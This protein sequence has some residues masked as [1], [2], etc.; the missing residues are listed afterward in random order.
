MIKV[1]KVEK[2]PVILEREKTRI[3]LFL[4]KTFPGKWMAVIPH[5]RNSHAEVQMLLSLRCQPN[6]QKNMTSQLQ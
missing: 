3:R 2:L 6:E 5:S 4:G 1:Q